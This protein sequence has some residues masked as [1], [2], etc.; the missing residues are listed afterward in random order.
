[1]LRSCESL[2][3]EKEDALIE[4]VMLTD[5]ED[6]SRGFSCFLCG[7][8][9][10]RKDSCS[11]HMKKSC[12]KRREA[13]VTEEIAKREEQLASRITKMVSKQIE[14]A[15]DE[16]LKSQHIEKMIQNNNS[17]QLLSFGKEKYDHISEKDMYAIFRKGFNAVPALVEK[18]Y[19]DSAAPENHNCVINNLRG[20]Y[21]EVYVDGEWEVRGQDDVIDDV[22]AF[23]FDKLDEFY[24]RRVKKLPPTSFRSMTRVID[25][26]ADP[27]VKSKGLRGVKYL[28]YNKR[29]IVQHE[30][31]RAQGL[32]SKKSI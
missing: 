8:K 17:V 26:Q 5:T 14:E 19:F 1:M 10:A 31:L 3:I 4:P 12:P 2:E 13:V 9:F 16:M 27:E 18:T 25:G 7:K 32:S 23:T 20:D 28:M 24:T 15:K 30:R 11:R 29:K 6:S 21:A 22:Y